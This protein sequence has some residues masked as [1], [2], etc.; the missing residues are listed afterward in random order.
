MSGLEFLVEHLT[1]VR[2][3]G[4]RYDVVVRV[5]KP[6]PDNGPHACVIQVTP[7]D[8]EPV[9]IY[10]EGPMQA[11]FLGLQ[12]VRTRLAGEEDYQGVRFFESGVEA[13][14]PKDWRHFWYGEPARSGAGDPEDDPSN[15]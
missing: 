14:E 8:R 15:S 13:Q 3:D 4:S 1:A 6:Y 10:G 7:L 12:Y 5:G 2:R 9:R 11:L